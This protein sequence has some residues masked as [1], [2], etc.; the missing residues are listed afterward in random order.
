MSDVPIGPQNLFQLYIWLGILGWW[1]MLPLALLTAAVAIFAKHAPSLVRLIAATTSVLLLIPVLVVGRMT[2]DEMR[3]DRVLDQQAA[4]RE[5]VEADNPARTDE[6]LA[7]C[8]DRCPELSFLNE[9]MLDAVEAGAVNSVSH[10]ISLGV[11]V[12]DDFGEPETDIRLCDG[13]YVPGLDA[14]SLAVALGNGEVVTRLLPASDS[15]SHQS[16]LWNAATMDRLEIVQQFVAEGVPITISGEV[17]DENE[18]LLN[19]AASGAAQRVGRWLIEVK[20]FSANGAP[21]SPTSNKGASPLASLMRYSSEVPDSPDLEPFMRLLLDA[22]ADLDIGQRTQEG[23]RT[24]LEVA[25]DLHAPIGAEALLAAGAREEDLT[26][27]D[28]NALHKILSEALFRKN[29]DRNEPHCVTI[30][31]Q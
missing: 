28:R 12:R 9:L 26:D 18:T 27:E 22:G 15:D 1:L 14:L 21:V 17:L 25:I 8:G 6:M 31:A 4:V 20:G 2:L 16:A 13:R 19:A 29:L 23:S 3:D 5:A 10:L 11:R 24:A 7:S 30:G